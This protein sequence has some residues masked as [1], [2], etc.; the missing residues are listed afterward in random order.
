MDEI[1]KID[2]ISMNKVIDEFGSIC[3]YNENNEL[4][5]EDEPAMECLDGTKF[6]YKNG[7]LHRED[8]PAIESI[9]S[10]KEWYKNGFLHREDG[11]AI[12]YIN[13]GKEYYYNGIW[14]PEIKTDEEWI[15]FIKLIMFQ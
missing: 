14:Y 6:W 1:Y 12:E 7:K 2:G 15:R 5:G 3:Y 4:H 10:D 11:P 13:G 8:G 9:N